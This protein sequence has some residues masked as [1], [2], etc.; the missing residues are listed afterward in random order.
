MSKPKTAYLNALDIKNGCVEMNHGSGGRASAQLINTL[1]V[2]AFNN[3]FLSQG[4]DGAVLPL[5]PAG[6]KLVISTDAHVVSPLFFP[7]GDIGSL[8]VHGTV[9]DLAMMGAKPLW[10]S[11]SFIL[12]EGFPLRDLQHIAQ[13]MAQAAL[14]A[15]VLIVTGDT[16][17]VERGKGDGVYISTTGI[18]S[19]PLP[20][21]PAGNRA[22]PGDVILLSGTIGDHGITILSQRE[23][24]KFETDIQSDSAAL[25][26]LVA[27]LFATGSDIHVL[28]DPTRGGLAT[29]LNE[30]AQQS[31]VG[32]VLDEACIPLHPTVAAAC[33]FL[34]LDPL[35]IAN[36]GKLIAICAAADAEK[37]LAAMHAHPLAQS[38]AIIGE[39]IAD[40]A[41]FVQMKTKLGGSRMVDWLNGDQ[42]PRIC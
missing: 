32:I 34:G 31:G 41:H 39:V 28:R 2:T 19:V 8:A 33:E 22:R 20:I 40:N 16:K 13:S 12:E 29:S 14:A 10:M 37:L 25:H 42:L 7:G 21:A 38:A 30:I 18:G 1:F 35:Y 4:N 36:E 11:V 27:Q 6:Q 17:V 24:L 15:N 3:E 26:E 9:N 23:G 5:P